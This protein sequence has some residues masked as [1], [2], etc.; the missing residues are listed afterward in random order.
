MRRFIVDASV[1]LCWC[2][3]S[4]KT[5]YTEAVFDC[6]AAGDEAL[7]PAVWPLEIVN[8]LVVAE[9]QKGISSA[10]LETF[11]RDLKD[12]PLEVDYEGVERVYS[13]ILRISR[14]LQLSSYDAAYLDL[15]LF[16]GL[17]LATLDR[18]LRFAAKRSGVELLDLGRPG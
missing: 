11:V 14:Q 3:E 9:R 8:S 4:Q 17:P 1:S 18:N 6:L 2:F 12:L 15:A 10:Q 13:S 7:V 5:A 16:E